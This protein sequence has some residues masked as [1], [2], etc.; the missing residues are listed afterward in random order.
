MLR[1]Q[2]GRLSVTDLW[3]SSMI[4]SNTMWGKAEVELCWILIFLHWV[5]KAFFI[6]TNRDWLGQ[7]PG[8]FDIPL[9]NV[10]LQGGEVDSSLLRCQGRYPKI[11]KS[12]NTPWVFLLS[13]QHSSPWRPHVPALKVSTA[14]NAKYSFTKERSASSTC[15]GQKSSH[16]CYS[17]QFPC[18]FR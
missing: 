16:Y 11:L 3:K 9:K 18:T 7:E 5:H 17:W 12:T 10:W 1:L 6:A 13:S 8:F 15:P 2:N 14:V 4:I